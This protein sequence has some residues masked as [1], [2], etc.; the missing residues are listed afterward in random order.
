VKPR[1][2]GDPLDALNLSYVNE[3]EFDRFVDSGKD[4]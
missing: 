4:G 2:T 1:A 3:A